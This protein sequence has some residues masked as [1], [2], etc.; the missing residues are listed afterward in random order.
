[1]WPNTM[2][3]ATGESPSCATIGSGLHPCCP[4]SPLERPQRRLRLVDDGSGDT[5]HRSWHA[6]LTSFRT[7]VTK[8]ILGCSD[9]F[10]KSKAVLPSWFR[11]PDFVAFRTF[12]AAPTPLDWQTL[13]ITPSAFWYFRLFHFRYTFIPHLTTHSSQPALRLAVRFRGRCAPVAGG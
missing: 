3:G 5:G 11:V 10:S 6:A 1:M 13:Y 12:K 9:D 4:L 2:L 8:F 7:P